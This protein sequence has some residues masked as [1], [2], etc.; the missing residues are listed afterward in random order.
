[1]YS[2]VPTLFNSY[3]YGPN[4]TR[5]VKVM[6]YVFARKLSLPSHYS[7][8]INFTLMF[9]SSSFIQLDPACQVQID[10]LPSSTSSSSPSVPHRCLSLSVRVSLVGGP[11]PRNVQLDVSAPSF[12]PD[13]HPWLDPLGRLYAYSNPV[14]DCACSLSGLRSVNPSV[15]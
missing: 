12:G 11:V 7:S 1:M 2:E 8:V 10:S 5:F 13:P 4:R 14:P 3:R 15:G 6:F 9:H